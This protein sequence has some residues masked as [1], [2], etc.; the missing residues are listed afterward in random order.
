MR[1]RVSV[2]LLIAI[3]LLAGASAPI[4]LGAADVAIPPGDWYGDGGGTCTIYWMYSP[5]TNRWVIMFVE[6]SGCMYYNQVF[7]G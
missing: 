1:R 2:S 3:I 5:E 7:V 6:G 4:A